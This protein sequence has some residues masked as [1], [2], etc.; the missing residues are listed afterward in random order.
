MFN[1]TGEILGLLAGLFT[2]F[3]VVPQVIRIYRTKSARDVSLLFSVMFVIGGLLWLFY[4]IVDRLL[5][6]IIWNVLGVTFNVTLMIGK[7]IYMK[8]GVNR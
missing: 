4:G 5:P 2:T 3:G 1:S 8:T 7:L 6:I